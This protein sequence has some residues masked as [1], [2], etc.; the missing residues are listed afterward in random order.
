M[1]AQIPNEEWRAFSRDKCDRPAPR[2]AASPSQSGFARLVEHELRNYLQCALH[3]ASARGRFP[4]H[5]LTAVYERLLGNHRDQAVRR[6]F[7]LLAAPTMRGL[8][9]SLAASGDVRLPR[10][11]DPQDLARWLARL[12]AVDAHSGLMIDLHYFAGL[13]IRETAAVLGVSRQTIVHDLR[14]ARDWLFSYLGRRSGW[15]P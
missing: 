2:L 10:G 11:L 15:G 7:M 8:W 13:S 9:L 12:D 14:C 6:K 3:D 4:A 1:A 5:V